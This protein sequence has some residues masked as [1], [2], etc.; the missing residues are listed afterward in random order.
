MY[1][2]HSTPLL[3]PTQGVDLGYFVLYLE[4]SETEIDMDCTECRDS[5]VIDWGT[6]NRDALLQE[7][8]FQ[9]H[10]C[11]SYG[12]KLEAESLAEDRRTLFPSSVLVD[13]ATQIHTSKMVAE[14]KHRC[15]SVGGHYCDIWLDEPGRCDRC[16]EDRWR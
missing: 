4:L 3:S 13:A 12:R 10:C 2:P 15:K 11:C 1:H 9:K 16:E 7:I 8:T 6:G 5:G 14:G